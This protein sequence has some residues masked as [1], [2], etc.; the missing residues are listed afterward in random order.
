[1]T[2]F[3]PWDCSLANSLWFKGQRNLSLRNN[4]NQQR[5]ETARIATLSQQIALWAPA[6]FFR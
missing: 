2:S 1:V 6:K 4:I 5:L 3:R